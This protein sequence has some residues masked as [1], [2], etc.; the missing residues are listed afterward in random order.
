MGGNAADALVG[1]TLCV[2]VIGMQ[3]SGIGGGGFM[4]VRGSD[5]TYESI[6]FRET[7]P[8][9]AHENMYRDNVNGSIRTGL[10]SGVPGDVHGLE[11]LHK[12]YGV[13][14][15][16]LVLNN[17]NNRLEGTSLESLTEDLVR[18]MKAATSD[19]NN[20]LVEDPNW[21]MDFAPN[22][23][24]LGVGDILTR[25]R[26]ADT[27]EVI[28]KHGS[29]GFYEGDVAKYTI[30]ALQAANGTMTLDDLKSYQVSI[31]KPINISYRGYNLY[32]CGAPSG[33]SVALSIIKIVEGYNMSDPELLTLNTHRLDEAMRFSYAARAELG[34]PDFFSYM[35]SF[36]EQML[37]PKTASSIR[38]RISDSRTHNVS[39]YSPTGY[40]VPEN[41]GTSHI[42]ASDESG[43]SITL[44]STI[45]LLFGSQL[46]VP[47]TGVIMNNEMNDFSIP[48]VPNAFGFV[49][50][51]INYIRPFKR[52][53]SSVSP[54]IV[55]HPNGTLYISIGGAG[56]SRIITATAQSILHILDHGLTL[57]E[58]LEHPRLHDQLVPATTTFEYGF[59]NNTV[60]SMR[61]K[62]H[63]ITWVGPIS[64]VQGV[65]RL[66]NGTFEAGSEP[67]QKNSGGLAC[68]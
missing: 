53:L 15:L 18:Y 44:T 38:K 66:S 14:D 5:G 33:G 36:E 3:H 61:E 59:D 35:D 22:G 56:G 6:D 47:E 1:T 39:Y 4:L 45:N 9:A 8:A 13:N 67:R 23:T 24:L 34:D 25:K 30:A 32:S 11:Y 26:Y 51:P 57:P 12:K 41:H 2:G 65:R 46:I 63:N 31:R 68:C 49:P 27:L 43:L 28:A 40:T 50:S 54:V 42:V 64:A 19:D 17:S 21:A 10:A 52:P 37:K 16:L 20:F 7:A 60:E 55:E 48:G 58:A 29:K 62:G